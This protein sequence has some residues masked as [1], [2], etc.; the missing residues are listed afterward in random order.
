MCYSFVFL[1][2]DTVSNSWV[3]QMITLVGIRI[4]VGEVYQSMCWKARKNQF[5]LGCSLLLCILK[6]IETCMNN[7]TFKIYSKQR[8]NIMCAFLPVN[9][10]LYY[11]IFRCVRH[12]SSSWHAWISSGIVICI[13][14]VTMGISYQEFLIHFHFLTFQKYVFFIVQQTGATHSL[15][16]C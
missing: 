14:F 1:A 10:L 6:A 13:L 3:W 5:F 12:R 4:S 11:C 15:Y 16:L 2:A 7:V 8:C 9:P